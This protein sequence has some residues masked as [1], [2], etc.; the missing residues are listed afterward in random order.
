MDGSRWHAGAVRRG[1]SNVPRGCLRLQRRSGPVDVSPL[2]REASAVLDSLL[3]HALALLVAE[4][5][6]QDQDLVGILAHGLVG[7]GVPG[8]GGPE[9]SN[10]PK[11]ADLAGQGGEVFG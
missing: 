6:E 8:T 7:F 1:C 2:V 5:V 9:R 4:R 3:D 11:L 10:D